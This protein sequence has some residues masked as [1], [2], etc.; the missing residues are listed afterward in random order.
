MEQIS[1][2]DPELKKLC[3]YA[4]DVI[5]SEM[6]TSNPPTPSFPSKYDNKEYPLFVTWTTGPNKVLRGCIGTFS[7]SD[8]K[9]NLT[10][11]AKIAAFEDRRFTPITEKE[12]PTLNC[13]I[14]LL[15]NFEDV[16]D[17][18]DWEIG[19]H[20]I[21]IEIDLDRH[22]RATYLPQVAAE[23]NWDKQTTLR[24]LVMKSGCDEEFEKV[25][26]KIKMKRYQS[27]KIEMTYGEYIKAKK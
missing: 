8:L 18:Y 12:L 14:S 15:V 11:Y 22:Y 23:Q 4:F 24:Y 13:G 26:D 3:V 7:S 20:G 1:E 25:A 6:K 2:S 21:Q 10:D 19:K 5:S 9:T 17:I 27:I 16:K